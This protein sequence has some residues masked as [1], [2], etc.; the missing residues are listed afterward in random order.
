MNT[1][2]TAVAVAVLVGLVLAAAVM[3]Y[4]LWRAGM[5][6]KPPL[7]M[8]QVL[9]REGVD[10]DR[11]QDESVLAQVGAAARTCLLCRDRDTCVAW[12]EGEGAVPLDHFCPNAELIGRMKADG[13]STHARPT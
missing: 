12:L 11:C 13:A 7:L 6:E 5:R 1:L 2:I 4:Q 8:H 3:V 10:L 9:E